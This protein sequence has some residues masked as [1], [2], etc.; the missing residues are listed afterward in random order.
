MKN[1]DYKERALLLPALVIVLAGAGL[2]GSTATEYSEPRVLRELADEEIDESSGLELSNAH[3]DVLWTHNDD[4]G[5]DRLFAIGLDG[6]TQGIHRL[7]GIEVRDWEDLSTFEMDGVPYLLCADVGNNK[8]KHDQEGHLYLF[9][10]PELAEGKSD[11]EVLSRISFR[12]EDDNYN[13]EAVAVD[14]RSGSI[15][16]A[17]KTEDEDASGLYLLPLEFSASEDTRVAKRLAPLGLRKITSMDISR[18]GL[19][20]VII[21]ADE[22]YEVE[23]SEDE[24]WGEAAVKRLE[25]VANLPEGQWEAVC[26]GSDDR[27]V[28]ITHEETPTRLL[29]LRPSG[30]QG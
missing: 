16:L 15:L 27:T 9:R 4:E 12:F 24:S 18:D 1:R 14:T 3:R 13:C 25:K 19:R 11:L 17:T 22:L 30:S 28:Y 8:E 6:R 10:E 26:Y 21:A 2:T 29:L 23:R 5:D 7:K 20:A